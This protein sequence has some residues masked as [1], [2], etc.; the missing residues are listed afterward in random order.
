VDVVKNTLFETDDY[1]ARVEVKKVVVEQGI[2]SIGEEAFY[3]YA[4]LTEA[5]LP[6]T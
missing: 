3:R 1:K 2:T 5:V 4:S 6:D